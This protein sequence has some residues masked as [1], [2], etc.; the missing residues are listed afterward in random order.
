MFNIKLTH[1][2]VY[3]TPSPPGVQVYLWARLAEMAHWCDE[4]SSDWEFD[5]LGTDEFIFI[6]PL[7]EDKV[8]FILRWL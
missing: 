6:F 2:D 8:K 1:N 4:N 3:N 5:G 7:E